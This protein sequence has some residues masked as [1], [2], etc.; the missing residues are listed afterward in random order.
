MYGNKVKSE[1]CDIEIENLLLGLDYLY[2]LIYQDRI[3]E[4]LEFIDKNIQH[5]TFRNVLGLLYFAAS[6]NKDNFFV[7]LVKRFSYYKSL[8]F[9]GNYIS[10]EIVKKIDIKIQCLIEKKSQNHY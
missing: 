8:S 6:Y 2:N 10:D 3:T 4:G 9:M 5:I 1:A 7:E